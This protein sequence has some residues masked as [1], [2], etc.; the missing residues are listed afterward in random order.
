MGQVKAY[1]RNIFLLF[2]GII[3]LSHALVFHDHH[4]DIFHSDKERTVREELFHEKHHDE[5]V[6][7]HCH[8]FNLLINKKIKN[9]QKKQISFHNH[10][11]LN[12]ENK[13]IT[14]P[15]KQFKFAGNRLYFYYPKTLQYP[16][17]RAP[18]VA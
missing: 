18:P 13:I 14:I 16:S 15:C 3:I 12:E 9:T 4:F 5:D 1:I 6:A 10:I 7:L 8:A 17:L 11:L 2:S